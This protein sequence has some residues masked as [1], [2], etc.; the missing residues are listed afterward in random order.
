[1]ATKDYYKILGV[2]PEATQ[3][4]IRSRWI[5]LTK[6]YHPDLVRTKEADEKIK[7]INEAYEILKNESTR[8]DYDFE[9][10]LKRS[11][12]KKVHRREERRMNLRKIIVP[13][14][15]L[16]LLLLVGFVSMRWFHGALPPKPEAPYKGDKGIGKETTSKIPPVETKSKL[17]GEREAPGGI[18]Q[19]QKINEAKE[20]RKE[21]IIQES[22]K[23]VSVSPQPPP[24]PKIL[25]KS[26]LPVRVEEKAPAKEKPKPVKEPVPQV[27]MKSEAPARVEREIR[28]E[29]PKEV[30]KEVPKEDTKEFPKE[31]PKEVPREVLKEVPKEVQREVPKEIPKEVPREIA[32]EVPT[33]VAGVT[34]HPGEKLTIKMEKEKVLYSALPSLAQEEEVKR[35]FS[36]Y[37]SRYNQ[38]DL[39]GFLSFFSSK[40]VQNGKDGFAAIR[41]IYSKF[42]N[43][44]QDLR[45]QI[46]GMKIEIYQ[47]SVDVKA[48][49]RVDQRL[50]KEG[51]EK[52]WKGSIHWVLVEENGNLKV[53]SIDYQNESSP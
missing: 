1:M 33:E 37:I 12:V 11:V 51:G 25:P 9:R 52:I 23:I 5:E 2:G 13:S 4:E 29:V 31:I 38:K 18:I 42:F 49:F 43:Q 3:E 44:S 15:V 26:E 36:K 41:N 19:S 34:L 17:Q 53:S 27:A 10:D 22:K 50:K 21:V 40:A 35:F 28:K 6:L 45:Y 39:D 46:E 14:A 16:V 7:E 30:L 47:N 24:S 20:I 48:R 32:K 8:F